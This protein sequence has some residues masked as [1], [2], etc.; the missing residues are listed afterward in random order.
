MVRTSRRG[1]SA[2]PDA[3]ITPPSPEKGRCIDDE[4]NCF[5]A[6]LNDAMMCE[7]KV[8]GPDWC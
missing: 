1:K 7:S 8:Q 5:D 3:L 2:L 6:C 4:S